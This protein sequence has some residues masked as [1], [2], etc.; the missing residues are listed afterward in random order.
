MQ[1]LWVEA[2]R[3][4]WMHAHWKACALD[5]CA[6]DACALLSCCEQRGGDMGGRLRSQT[7]AS[8]IID[9]ARRTDVRA[10]MTLFRGVC[11][12]GLGDC[13]RTSTM[14]V[15][16]RSS[17]DSRPTSTVAAL[18]SP[19]QVA[20]RM[21]SQN[22]NATT[23]EARVMQTASRCDG[24]PKS[25]RRRESGE[26]PQSKRLAMDGACSAMDGGL[27]AV[28]FSC[29]VG[30]SP[31]ARQRHKDEPADKRRAQILIRLFIRWWDR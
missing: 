1:T 11:A 16:T 14:Q 19:W 22:A 18:A 31:L 21:I 8:A 13:R 9:S 2:T 24:R 29:R 25:S 28:F 3:Q 15:E 17:S 30:L 26:Q 27:H 10:S 5:A 23:S 7:S 6:L 12:S 20:T 4:H